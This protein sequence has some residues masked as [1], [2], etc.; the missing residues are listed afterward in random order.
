MKK[1][2]NFLLV[3]ACGTA[4]AQSPFETGMQKAFALW[5]EDKPAEA[6]AMFERIAAAEQQNWLPSYYIALVNTTEAFRTKDKQKVQAL[7]AK[8]QEA[9]DMAMMIMP[10]NAELLVMQAMIH[11]AWI[12]YDPMTNG[13]KLSGKVNELYAKAMKLAPDNPRVV[14]C[15]AEFDMGAAA[16][17]GNDTAPM[18]AEIARAAELFANFKPQTPFHPNWGQD[19]AQQKLEECKK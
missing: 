5:S 13:M 16:Y 18:C 3:L 7:L 11:T 9:Q 4:M 19:R 2:V 8:A 6:S 12:A 1:F 14:F 17:F 10:D 15:K